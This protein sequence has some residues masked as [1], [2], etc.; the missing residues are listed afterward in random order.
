MTM[1]GKGFPQTSGR[2]PL[3]FTLIE[4]MIA[5]VIVAILS[6]IAV[7]SY[8]NATTRSRRAAVEAH[9]QDI[10]NR[11]EQVLLDARGYATSYTTPPLPALP[12]NLSASYTVT[13]AA[14]NAATPP[15]FTI[16]A[17]PKGR[18]LTADTRCGTLTLNQAGTKTKSGTATLA[19]CW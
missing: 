8:S 2:R 6:T 14:N 5:V 7:N 10:A 11:Q 15:T 13:V 12:S 4:L 9:L 19:E 1:E 16:T 17:T 3:G 18:Q